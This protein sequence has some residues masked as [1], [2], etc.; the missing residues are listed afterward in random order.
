[1]SASY[2]TAF[3]HSSESAPEP[4]VHFS[5]PV[6]WSFLSTY[7]SIPKSESQPDPKRAAA[8]QTAI[9]LVDEP[10][11]S[12]TQAQ[13]SISE[14]IAT[15]APVESLEIAAPARFADPPDDHLRFRDRR[16]PDRWE[17]VIPKMNRPAARASGKL[18]S[19]GPQA[20]TPAAPQGMRPA[21]RPGTEN[22]GPGGRL[23]IAGRQSSP[24][25]S[26][27]K[28]SIFG[29]SFEHMAARV[30]PSKF[31]LRLRQFAGI[32]TWRSRNPRPMLMIGISLVALLVAGILLVALKPDVT[33][34]RD[35]SP[36]AVETGPALQVDPALWMTLSESPRQINVVRDSMQLADFRMDFQGL[37]DAKASG[38]VFRVKD[39]RNYYAMSVEIAKPAASASAVLKRFAVIDGRD[40]PVTQILVAIGSQPGALY[41]VRTEARGSKFTTWIADRKVDEW[42]DARLSD[43]GVGLYNDR[44]ESATI[45]ADLAVFPLMR[46]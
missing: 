27:P 16:G 31:G 37:A 39:A 29:P 9:E 40:Q 46:E 13:V 26:I 4:I 34:P 14:R 22:S 7:P 17:M 36:S 45:V 35:P 19:E 11:E 1:M 23:S 38:W 30:S 6:T 43:G 32:A 2:S 15:P 8:V 20:R 21:T 28:H 41:K 33:V 12:A 3:P 25:Q 24:R 5:F 10:S 42:T 18:I 44:G